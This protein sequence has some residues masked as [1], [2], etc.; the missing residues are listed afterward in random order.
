MIHV[1]FSLYDKNGRYSKFTGTAMLSLFEN[2]NTPPRLPSITVHIL[3]D[4]TLTQDNRD[5]FIY[6]AVRYAQAVKFY[7][8]EEL[9]ADKIAEFKKLLP[10]ARDSTRT[11]AMFFRFLITDLIRENKKIIYL[12]S[13]IIVNMDI[14]E[15]WRVELG[16]KILAVVPEMRSYVSTNPLHYLCRENFVRAED[17]FNSGVLVMNLEKLRLEEETLKRGIKFRTQHTECDG[18]D[19]S[20]LNYCFST[21]TLKCWLNSR[22]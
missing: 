20:I 10:F 8:V 5:K 2:H 16:D 11:V 1:C 17:F 7:N 4:N 22:A 6:L 14:N 12:D 9:C 3:H 15:L 18:N 21:K 19:Q 13:D